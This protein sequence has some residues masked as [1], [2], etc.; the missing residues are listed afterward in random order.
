[1]ENTNKIDRN[2][3][4]ININGR[5]TKITNSKKERRV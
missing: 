4:K 2:D 3:F 5:K 1:M